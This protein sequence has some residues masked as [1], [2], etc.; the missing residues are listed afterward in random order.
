M[1]ETI[2]V[3]LIPSK[4]GNVLNFSQYDVG[5]VSRISLQNGDEAYTIP[6]GATVTIEA[7]KPS[8]LG[9]SVE[10]TYSGSVVTVISTETMTNEYG[11]FP[12]ELRIENGD[13]LLGT[14]NFTFNVEK[15]PH[16]DGTT[17][18][19]AESV[20]NEITLALEN[21]LEEIDD[22]GGLTKDMK[23]AI[24]R[25]F[26]NVMWT[27]EEGKDAYDNLADQFGGVYEITYDL[28]NITL[29]N[30]VSEIVD[31]SEYIAALSSNSPSAVDFADVSVI[32][33][34]VD[35]TSQVYS[36]GVI[37]IPSV[38]GNISISA[39][40]AEGYTIYGF[41]GQKS[42]TTTNNGIIT[43][44][45]YSTDYSL[46]TTTYYNEGTNSPQPIMGTRTGGSYKSIGIFVNPGIGKIGYWL[47]GTDTVTD[48]TNLAPGTKNKISIFP[49]GYSETYP[50]N[51][52]I[53]ANGVEYNSASSSVGYTSGNYFT[54][55]GYG[56]SSTTSA[57]CS[58]FG[59]RISE[60]IMKNG[61]TY[62]HCLIPAN[63]G[64]NNGFYDV[65]TG[66]FYTGADPTLFEC[67]NWEE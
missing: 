52:V 37:D 36:D 32:M 35:V 33:N 41:V 43:D 65:V 16:P 54:L 64:T 22:A 61:S 14:T 9:F 44:I 45:A 28:V 11:R 24:L 27:S 66:K 62:V 13:V 26:Q 47:D 1:N 6:T 8:G 4:V 46:E 30:N 59:F 56:F 18:G 67:G 63:N 57:V 10:C 51:M 34:G 23:S 5:R 31:G 7:T 60:T 48:I 42:T 17:D 19:T 50:N 21:A 55:F 25:C 38:T 12:C 40:V 58:Y 49:V 20:V 53:V 29:D 15:S 39:K 3:N 2:N